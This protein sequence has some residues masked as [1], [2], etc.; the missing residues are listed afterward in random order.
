[1]ETDKDRGTKIKVLR[2]DEQ[3]DAA[4]AD[5]RLENWML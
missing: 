2:K 4:K 1:L 3:K 5:P